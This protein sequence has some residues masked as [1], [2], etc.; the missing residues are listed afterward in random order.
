MLP[1]QLFTNDYCVGIT[2]SIKHFHKDMPITISGIVFRML[3]EPTCGS[4]MHYSWEIASKPT[5]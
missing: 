4:R 5:V 3:L 2:R 1:V